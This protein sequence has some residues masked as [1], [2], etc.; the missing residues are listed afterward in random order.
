MKIVRLA[1]LACVLLAAAACLPVA[2]TTPVGTTV[3]LRPD[4]ALSGGMWKGHGETPG[5][6]V[7]AGFFAHDD[8]SITALL[9]SPGGKDEGWATYS[10]QT[11]TLGPYSYMNAREVSTDGKPVSDA[12]AQKMFPLLYRVNGDGA[13]VIYLMDENKAAAAVRAGRI[14]GTV[15][16]GSDGDVTITAPAADLDA[17]MQTPAGRALFVK[18]LAIFKKEK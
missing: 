3:G 14:A 6:T 13:L 11:A 7:Y 9:V 8:G 12:E 18:P 2:T 10:I 15:E 1:A 16:P 17:F 5:Q 4:P